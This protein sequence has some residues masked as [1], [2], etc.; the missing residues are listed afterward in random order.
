M[1][2]G[3]QRRA[4]APCRHVATAE[5]GHGGD[6]AALGDD[7]AIAHLPGERRFAFGAMA[8]GLPMRANRVHLA[9]C[10]SGI[11]GGLQGGVGESAGERGVQGAQLIK[12][13]CLAALAQCNQSRPQG[14]VPCVGSAKDELAM[15]FETD[16]RSINTV[17]AGARNQAEVHRRGVRHCGCR[18]MCR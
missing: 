6:A 4:V 5:I 17:G 3:H 16:Q 15:G 1:E 11:A 10:Q 14:L 9:W 8:N 13:S 12:G 2:S 18:G 7:I